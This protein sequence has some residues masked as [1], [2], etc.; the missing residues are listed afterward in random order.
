M[1]INQANEATQFR[2][3]YGTGSIGGINLPDFNDK[4]V[5]TRNVT[6]TSDSE[7]EK[8]IRQQAY[9]DYANGKFQ[10]ESA[11]FNKLMKSYVSEVSP[12][13]KGIIT[14]GLTAVA[15]NSKD[16]R[17][18]INFVATVLMGKVVY[19]NS[20]EG[21]NEYIEFYDE[22][23]ELVAKY[24]NNGWTILN[25]EA[26]TARQ[27]EMCT[28]YNEA[29][30]EAKRAAGNDIQLSELPDYLQYKPVVDVRV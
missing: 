23:G 18:P 2:K 14:E 27:I 7:Y 15:K 21:N 4:Y 19:Q 30:G 8:R 24:S 22:N 28:I 12:D 13:R 1:L 29:W 3:F 10:N 6:G 20:I 5:F 17:K 11:G 9:E 16:G 25:T 26:E